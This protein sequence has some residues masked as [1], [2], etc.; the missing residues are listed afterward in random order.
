M[1]AELVLATGNLHKVK[2]IKEILGKTSYEIL[3][4]L[5]FDLPEIDEDQDSLQGNSFKKAGIVATTIKK[6]AIADDTGL[7]VDALDGQPGIF[8]ARYAGEGCSFADNRAKMLRELAGET[9]RKAYF[10]TVITLCDAD[11]KIVGQCEGRMK[12][13][14]ALEEKGTRGFGYDNIFIPDGY[15]KTFSEL[16][17]EQK[18]EI[19]HRKEALKKISPIIEKYFENLDL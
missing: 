3:S 14:I 11:G 18:N 7:F 9:N 17:S 8:A 15:D 13:K 4:A 5:D 19:S 1:K 16:S 6:P 10:A 12:G 2:E